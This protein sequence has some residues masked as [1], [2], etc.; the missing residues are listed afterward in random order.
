[1]PGTTLFAWLDVYTSRKVKWDHKDKV[2]I[3]GIHESHTLDQAFKGLRLQIG[4][5][6]TGDHQES[7]QHPEEVSTPATHDTG[8]KITKNYIPINLKILKKWT[9]F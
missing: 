5:K 9:G 3:Q 4:D 1:V 7:M 2:N 6:H 8:Q